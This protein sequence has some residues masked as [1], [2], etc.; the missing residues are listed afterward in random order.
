MWL[1]DPFSL[2]A[3]EQLCVRNLLA[4]QAE[5]IFFKDD[6]GRFL[7]VSQGWLEAEGRG[8]SLQDV[9]GKT[10]FDIFSDPHAS[11]AVAGE[12]RVIETGEPIVAR[13][14]RE[15][16]DGDAPD[17]W[18]STTKMPLL[19]ADGTIV[20]TWGV[21]RDFTTQLGDEET[22]RRHAQGQAEIAELGRAGL[23]GA[24]LHELFDSAVGA[25]WRVLCSDC[26]WLVARDG[27]GSLVIRAEVGWPA[28]SEGGTIA[29]EENALLQYAADSQQPIVV[30]DWNREARLPRS[31]RR[32]ARG[33]RS[34]VAV[35]VGDPDSPFGLLEVQYIEPDAVPPDCLAFLTALAN[36][37]TEAIHSR[38][39]LAKIRSQGESLEAM[40]QSL[41]KLVHERERLIDQIPG[42][43]LVGEWHADGSRH[44]EYVSRR[45]ATILGVEPHTFI[46]D[47]D[48]FFANVHADDR[49]AFRSAVR[50]RAN[51]GQD[52]LPT[53]IRFLRPDGEEVW[54]RVEASVVNADALAHR[55]QAVLFDI[56]AAKQAE[57][58]RDRLELE[59]RLAQKL[60]AVGQLAA[61]VAHEINTPIQFIGDSVQFLKGAVDEMFVLTNVYRGLLHGEESI[62]REERQRRAE[63]ADAESDLDY[64]TERVPPAFE[65][66]LN[67]IERVTA[68][69]QAMRRFSHP[70][71]GALAHRHQRCDPDNADGRDERVQVRGRHRT[72]PR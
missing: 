13:L 27:D 66:A 7:M 53:E 12:Q 17:S 43:V 21:T 72:R 45:S 61:G 54:L 55:V 8:L 31:T 20:G 34:S 69:V 44:F 41:R 57:L 48:Y 33:V 36:V 30:E 5:R 19:D 6:K 51:A 1:P 38:N 64:L 26:A 46:E 24:P 29:E 68:I 65:R 11:Q 60:E 9:I 2:S 32:L 18:V 62:D 40:T 71:D 67:G 15:T 50:E 35:L 10:D 25:A 49:D 59:L 22:I 39:A 58:A 37:L 23:R 4:S 47:P 63:A 3:I 28:E 42:V 56:T 14:E 16:F 70:D 52:P